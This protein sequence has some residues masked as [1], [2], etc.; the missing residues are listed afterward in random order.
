MIFVLYDHYNI[1]IINFK[2]KKLPIPTKVFFSNL[3]SSW[4][5]D[6]PQLDLA[7]FGQEVNEG[8]NFF[9]VSPYKMA[10]CSSLLCKYGDIR[11]FCPH[12]VVVP[13]IEIL[14]DFLYFC[15]I[16]LHAY[17]NCIFW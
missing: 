4:V 1:S 13:R 15:H 17:Y 8:N 9:L 5:G 2:V 12:G 14:L 3:R 10:T 7:K 6:L 16:L 11:P